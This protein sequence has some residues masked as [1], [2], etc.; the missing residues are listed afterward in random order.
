MTHLHIEQNT[1]YTE[2][3]NSDIIAKLYEITY[4]NT[5]DSTSHLE[6]RL[7]STVAYYNHVSYLNEHFDNL[8]LSIDKVLLL[9][10][11]K[12]LESALVSSISRGSSTWA[13]QIAS[14]GGFTRE[15]AAQVENDFNNY[16]WGCGYNWSSCTSFME[17]AYFDKITGMGSNINWGSLREIDCSKITSFGQ[18]SGNFSSSGSNLR[19]FVYDP[20]KVVQFSEG[21]FWGCSNLNVDINF[22]NNIYNC[23]KSFKGSGIERIINPGPGCTSVQG[24]TYVYEAFRGCPKLKYINFPTQCTGITSVVNNG[25]SDDGYMLGDCPMLECVIFNCPSV[26]QIAS[27]RHFNGSTNNT[28]KIYVPDSLVNSYKSNTYWSTWSS[29]IFGI[30]QLETDNA[31]YY[32]LWQ[33]YSGV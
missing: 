22:P 9:F 4:N 26:F 29:K 2:E 31:E 28:F 1:G 19:T 8:Y 10:K 18:Y 21:V 27:T 16:F 12:S 3:V 30:S 13:N 25:G 33:S 5:L 7:H 6:G 20:S 14:D 23:Q 32:Q 15:T 24:G 11:D 17:L